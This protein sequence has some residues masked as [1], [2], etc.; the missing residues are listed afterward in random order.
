MTDIDAPV[1]PIDPQRDRQRIARA[2]A[3]RRRSALTMLATLGHPLATLAGGFVLGGWHADAPVVGAVGMMAAWIGA[4]GVLFAAT[5]LALLFEAPS[6]ARRLFDRAD[7]ARRGP[8]VFRRSAKVVLTLHAFAFAGFA[9]LAGVAAGLM[10][11]G[12][13]HAVD[14]GAFALLGLALGLATAWTEPG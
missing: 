5:S 3:A 9:A 13:V 14:V 10:G 12:G 2:E 11:P 1:E 4:R 8:P 7:E 6:L